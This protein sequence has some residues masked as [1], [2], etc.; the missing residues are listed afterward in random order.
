MD[1]TNL[2]VANEQTKW[3]VFICVCPEHLF[4]VNGEQFPGVTNMAFMVY[5]VVVVVL[6]A[7]AV[8]SS[9]SSSS[10]GSS[11]SSSSSSSGSSSSSSS[12]SS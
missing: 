4:Y 9:S 1:I 6:V 2:P 5:R 11:S 7:V 3:I 10:S 12:S 8:S